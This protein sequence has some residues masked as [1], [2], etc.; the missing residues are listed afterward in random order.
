MVDER[1]AITQVLCLIHE[2]RHQDHRHATV[3]HAF[4]EAPGFTPCLRIKP[5]GQLVE[6]GEPGVAHQSQRD[7]QPLFLAA[8]KAFERGGID[9]LDAQ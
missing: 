2:V 4:D 9:L 8:G 7:G 3:S 5:R 1:E 6:D